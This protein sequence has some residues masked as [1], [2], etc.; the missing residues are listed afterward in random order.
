MSADGVL[1]Y[2]RICN[3]FHIGGL[4]ML[5]LLVVSVVMWILIME[6]ALFLRRLGRK[7]MQ[8]SVAWEHVAAGHKPDPVR[9]QGGI[10]LLVA[11]FLQERTGNA[12]L[13]RF[14]LDEL[15]LTL[16]RSLNRFLP[17]IGVLAGIAPLLGL[18]G[19]VTGMMTTFEVLATYGTGNVRA[20]A[21]GISEALVSTETGLVI[22]I[23]G[24]YM[25]AF[26][27]RR[28]GNLKQRVAVAGY[29]LRRQ[30]KG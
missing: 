23:P 21:N 12:D 20:M 8:L 27:A 17:F 22:A 4:V 28:A 10:A 14:I 29:Y 3:Y 6:R 13:D 11:R 1:L 19:T 16:N 26:L 2:Y 25:H 24:L 18:L 15:V 30:I 7:P 9:H 5:P